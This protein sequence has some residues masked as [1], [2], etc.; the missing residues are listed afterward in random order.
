MKDFAIYLTKSRRRFKFHVKSL[1]WQ[2][3]ETAKIVATERYILDARFSYFETE[4]RRAHPFG[5]E[6]LKFV[7]MCPVEVAGGH[8]FFLLV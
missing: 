5:Q 2:T 4:M 6:S 1:S 3:A 8:L 7:E